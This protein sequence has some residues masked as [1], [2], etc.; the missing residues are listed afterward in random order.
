MV[1]ESF[2]STASTA[3]STVNI[4]DTLRVT[5]DYHPAG[6]TANLYEATVTIENLT[7]T[8]LTDIRYRRVIDWD[9]E[10]TAFSK[11]VTIDGGSATNLLFCQQRWIRH[12]KP[13]R[14]SN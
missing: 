13:A 12:G 10:P 8:A 5:H 6:A 9:I 14:R 4:E 1:L 2:S 7:E 11:F 3:L